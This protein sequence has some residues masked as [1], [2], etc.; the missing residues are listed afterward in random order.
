MKRPFLPS[1]LGCL[2][3]A[4]PAAYGQLPCEEPRHRSREACSLIGV[5]EVLGALGRG[6]IGMMVGCQRPGS[7]LSRC[8][9][10]GPELHLV[11]QV[12][13]ASDEALYR[14]EESLRELVTR[15]AEREAAAVE[16]TVVSGIRCW[17]LNREGD[18]TLLVGAPVA[19]SKREARFA[20]SVTVFPSGQRRVSPEQVRGL[21][22]TA[23]GR[24]RPAT[25]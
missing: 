11:Y 20:V 12:V 19:C 22:S 13:P 25:R 24:V 6:S 3:L 17:S 4:A 2:A 9:V 14:S 5:Q 15:A 1:L 8:D 21:V 10:T 16:E 18:R 23:V 7:L